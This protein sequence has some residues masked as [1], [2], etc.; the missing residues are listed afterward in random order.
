MQ[1]ESEMKTQGIDY[2]NGATNI[3]KSNGIRYGVIDQG[4]VIQ[5]W[6]DSSKL[7]Y[8]K[9]SE[10]EC[11]ECEQITAV[12]LPDDPVIAW[13]G[14]VLCPNC[15][16]KSGCELPDFAEPIAVTYDADGYICRQSG[17]DCDIFI[18]KSPYYTICEFCSPCAPGAG[19][20]MHTRE[21]GIKAY[22]FGHNWFEDGTAPYP[23]YKVSDNTLVTA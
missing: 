9:P 16:V 4:K 21:H 6:A 3:D 12:N 15:G 23:V 22:C 10:F 8:G 20:I 18:I 19:Y 11:L 7:D 5:A 14:M 17:D 13:G 2:G 1:T